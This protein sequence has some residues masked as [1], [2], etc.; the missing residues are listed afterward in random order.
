MNWPFSTLIL[1]LVAVLF[2]ILPNRE[3][4]MGWVQ[5]IP[6]GFPLWAPISALFLHAD[7]SHLSGN[8]LGLGIFY[9]PL[10][11]RLRARESLLV[12]WAAA[13]AGNLGQAIFTSR[14][15]PELAGQPQIGL[16]SLVYGAM[17]LCAVRF[18]HV[19]FMLGQVR[20]P[21]VLTVIG[22]LVVQQLVLLMQSMVNGQM[23]VGNAGHLLAFLFA[24][25]LAYAFGINVAATR[26]L[27]IRDIERYRQ[28]GDL[29][30][31]ARLCRQWAALEPDS[32]ASLLA[33]A[34]SARDLADADTARRYYQAA[35]HLLRRQKQTASAD[36]VHRESGI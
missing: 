22:L 14:F 10:E 2:Q 8:L 9:L 12:V 17:G 5:L 35:E 6:S 3:S 24:V 26:L 16:S 15:R 31:A 19:G 28:Q 32:P 33:A 30:A 20:I 4:W 29:I 27:L 7:W 1:L 11:L 18:A 34:R 13:F 25:A 23:Q 36:E 21:A